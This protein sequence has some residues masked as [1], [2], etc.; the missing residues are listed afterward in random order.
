VDE[1][2]SQ[3]IES[4]VTFFESSSIMDAVS[5]K[6]YEI[7]M[8]TFIF[9]STENMSHEDA[10]KAA[11]KEYDELKNIEKEL[12]VLTRSCSPKSGNGQSVDVEDSYNSR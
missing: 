8:L 4:Q 9:M 11:I 12:E 3:D 2:G 10:V 6:Q 1:Q 7:D 5:S